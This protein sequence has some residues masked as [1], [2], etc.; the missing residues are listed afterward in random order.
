MFA[1][2]NL[3]CVLPIDGFKKGAYGERDEFNRGEY[4]ADCTA[5]VSARIAKSRHVRASAYDSRS[6]WIS[7]YDTFS[8]DYVFA[9][10]LGGVVDSILLWLSVVRVDSR[11]VSVQYQAEHSR[12]VEF[13]VHRFDECTNG[14]H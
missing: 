7:V 11:C 5:E 13:K 9:E 12:V 3:L 6:R 8:R 1:L 4:G 14:R 2:Q 10:L